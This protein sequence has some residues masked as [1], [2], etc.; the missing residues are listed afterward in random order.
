[1]CTRP[2]VHRLVRS[3]RRMSQRIGARVF[4]A[5]SC[6]L[7]APAAAQW[8]TQSPV[9]TAL[10]VRGIAAPTAQRVFIATADD[11]FDTGGSL[12]E[13][14]DGGATWTQR[15]VPASLGDP[16]N[17]IGFLD[18]QNGWTFGNDNY[19]TTD[20]G[21]TW[22]QMP[23][24]GSTYFMRFYSPSFGLATGNFGR[25]VSRDGGTTWSASPND[26][27]AFDFAGVSLGLGVSSSGIYRTTDGGTTFGLVHAGDAA[28]V[29]FLSSSVAVGIADGGFVRST[30]GGATWTAGSSAGGR[31]RLTAVSA[32]VALAWG[33]AGTFPNYDDRV[34][35]SSDGGLTWTDLG[36]PMPV[37]A[38]A[39][40]VP[41]PLVVVGADLA[42]NLFRSADAGATW[43][44]VFDS[45]GP[46]PSFL[47]SAAPVFPDAST[48]Y[49]GCGAGFVIGTTDGGA[50]WSQISSG[51]GRSLHDIGRFPGG[52]MIAV[53]ESGTVLTSTGTTPWILHEAS[54]TFDLAA[55]HVVGPQAVVAVDQQGRVY[56]SSDGGVSWIAGAATP[57]GLTA[58][59]LHFATLSDGWVIGSGFSGA[60]LYHTTDGGD[61]WTPVTT[62]QGGYTAVDFE[63]SNGWAANVGGVFYRSTDQ[64]AT[65]TQGQL[66]GSSL[67]IDDMDFFDVSIGYAVG[68][69]GYAARTDDAGLTW[70]I[71]PTPN[72]TD[73]LTDIHLVGA[74]ELWISTADG[75]A[76]YSATGGQ[77]WA[78]LDIGSPGFGSFA[79]IAADAA[80]NAWT[81]G[82]QGAI[83]HF[84]GPPPPPLNRPP[85]SSFTFVT[86]GLR[87]D[88]T[89]TSSDPDG[90]V[91]S[92]LWDFG[93]GTTSTDTNPTHLYETADTYI[94]RLTV[95]DD[96]GATGAS[97]RFIVV[98]PGP[99]G[100]FGDF[101][102]VT[103]LDPLF[104]TPQ[105][106]DFWVASAAPADYDGDGDLDI[107]VLGFYVVY[108]QSVQ[109]RLVL[110]RNDGPAA[111]NEWEF[112]YI[113][114]PIGT[115]SAGASDLAW[116][117]VDGDGDPDLAVGSDGQ[118]VIYRNDAGTLVPSGTTLPPY[119]EQNDQADFDLRSITWADYD[120][121]GDLDLLLP[122]VFDF[123]T[124][125]F[126]TAL[127]RNDGSN[128]SGGWNFTEV[129]AGLAPTEHAQSAWADFDGDQDLDLL[130]VH[131]SPLTEDGFIRRYRND[132]GGVFVGE[133][134]LGSLRVEHG[135][136]Q[137]GDYDDDG[138]LDILVAGNVR[139][140]DGSYA[141]VLRLYRNDNETYVPIEL[142]PC[143]PCEGWW[144]LTA[145]TW[146]DYDSDGDM[147]ILLTG[148]YNSGSQI[149]GR[150]KIYDNQ[151][152]IFTDS[153]NQLPA[154]RASGSRGGTF[155]WLD[156][157]GEGDLDYFIAGEYFVPGG[158]GLVEA[159]MHVYRNDAPG[160][161]AAPSPPTGLTAN[162][163]GGGGS[164][165]LSWNA[166]SDDHTPGA[167]LTYD[168]Q[169]HRDG[170]PVAI[171]SHL[172]EP[173]SISTGTA[174][175][176]SGL[177]EGAYTWTL[178][179]VDSAYNGGAVAQ[180][181]FRV[182]SP[183][184]VQEALPRDVAFDRNHPN[185]FR[186]S[187]TFRFALPRPAQVE[188]SIYDVAGR[189][190]TRLVDGTRPA[191]S[192][193]VTWKARNAASGT[194]FAR[195]TTGGFTRTERIQLL[196]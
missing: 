131:L 30:D 108:F 56:R 77:S 34:L 11:P 89:D 78:V 82:F 58:A 150:A 160:Q 63:G 142:I 147:D 88:F 50:T 171:A 80:G 114:A 194:Y 103:P 21:T 28:A 81:V 51:T 141:T 148:T 187:T 36:E 3:V 76:Y 25:S 49:F 158:N 99:G 93:D 55:V 146:A 164:V 163:A 91:V 137:W 123:G 138:D 185:P 90:I 119:Y 70:E 19:R 159:Q 149:E 29:V 104:V 107:A 45:P 27:F 5:L 193:V 94:V 9:P 2:N 116:G 167:A 179:A 74:N 10:D 98:Q 173:G 33:R 168:L 127:M 53:G 79:A 62:F 41:G 46:V 13:S 67:S 192:H 24:L 152:G 128:G 92:R 66:P 95:T 71:L 61:S 143:V 47:S 38:L 136:A 69:W 59:D 122:S 191:G 72:G 154:P 43:S 181:E 169:L 40:V 15:D 18:S 134:I 83:E 42:G 52:D 73:H 117:D 85:A 26:L 65:W 68:R 176:L 151:G 112:A 170:V 111:P 129:D 139:E 161:N 14:G 12:F 64:G 22:T 132:G 31:T 177:P 110:L 145:A 1:M 7:A 37:G 133:D 113:D 135:E 97:V 17:G 16:L 162:T 100:T 39:F 182:G 188:L 175:T 86:T 106:E 189:L 180:S 8:A 184:G 4:V 35:R 96:D 186:G 183:T 195:F 102:E 174:W 118:T 140:T 32:G 190:V 125:E 57:L 196:R 120:N 126:R 166:A 84:T 60:A 130:L 101:T 144:D 153:G 172:P 6:L 75:V 48:G 87:V 54:S 20:G 121:D 44:Q 165:V 115:L 105:D 23:F 156:L 109:E 124:F 155:T 178:R 157:D